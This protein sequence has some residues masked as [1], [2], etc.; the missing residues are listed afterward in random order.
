MHAASGEGPVT[1]EVTL[2]PAA[3]DIGSFTESFN[4]QSDSGVATVQCLIGVTAAPPTPR[5]TIS[6]YF[7]YLRGPSAPSPGVRARVGV[8]NLSLPDELWADV[9]PAPQ[10]WRGLSFRYGV[11]TLPIVAS[12]GRGEFAVQFPYDLDI[13]VRAFTLDLVSD[14]GDVL[15]SGTI[16]GATLPASPGLVDF[17][18]PV[19]YRSDGTPVSADN[20]VRSGDHVF[21]SIVGA[22]ATD[23]SV[24]AG[25][26]PPD[27]V[28]AIPKT[29]VAVYIS[30]K[31]A[32][33]ARQSLSPNRI[34]VT[35]LEIEVPHLYSG[36]HMLA[37][38][39]SILYAVPLYVQN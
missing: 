12:F 38:G 33:V 18:E 24:P 1:F 11:T 20:P 17:G 32:S 37:I 9:S 27:G 36:K 6:A 23:P 30:G 13:G 31:S 2:D 39:N 10:S 5:P 29:P 21:L 22:G 28:I 14:S 35:D 8:R 34:G 7:S 26:L 4:V 3:F 19:V 15:A 25:E 16:Y